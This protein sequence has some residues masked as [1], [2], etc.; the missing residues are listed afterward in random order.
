MKATLKLMEARTIAVR[1]LDPRQ[2]FII[3]FDKVDE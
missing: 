1:N 3:G 2:K